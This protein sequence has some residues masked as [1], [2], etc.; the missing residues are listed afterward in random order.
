VRT[1]A[2]S[3][4]ATPATPH[5]HYWADGDIFLYCWYGAS[6]EAIYRFSLPANAFDVAWG[7]SGQAYCCSTGQLI[8]TGTRITSTSYAIRVKVTYARSYA[9]NRARVSYSTRVRI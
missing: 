6:A 1:P 2:R 7:V 4:S 8:R 5:R 9:V 3:T